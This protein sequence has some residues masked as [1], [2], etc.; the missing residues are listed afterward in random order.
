MEKYYPRHIIY[1]IKSNYFLSQTNR[2]FFGTKKGIDEI[3]LLK[4]NFSSEIRKQ[5]TFY[6]NNYIKFS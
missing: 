6:L 4:L 5:F 2:H 1:S 3:D